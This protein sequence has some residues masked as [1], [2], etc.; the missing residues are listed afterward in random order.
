MTR[1]LVIDDDDNLR[2]MLRIFLESLG[3][4]VLEARDGNEGIALFKSTGA[5]AVITD[6]IMPGREGLETIGELKRIKL[7]IMIIAISGGERIHAGGNLRMAK[8]LGAAATLMK[9][10]T[11]EELAD[12]LGSLL[13]KS[14]M[15]AETTKPA[16]GD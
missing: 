15:G 10:F 12:A 6:L 9:P 4:S 16:K 3:C 1:V 8:H 2:T 13:Q 11:V 7:G 5:D 14:A